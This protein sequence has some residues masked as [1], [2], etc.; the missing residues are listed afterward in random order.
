[1]TLRAAP[2]LSQVF[3]ATGKHDDAS[4]AVR[5][6]WVYIA[7]GIA[8]LGQ[9]ALIGWLTQGQMQKA[10][11]REARMDQ[12][13]EALALC[14]EGNVQAIRKRC[15]TLALE[16]DAAPTPMTEQ[17]VVENDTSGLV[18]SR[19]LM[20]DAPSTVGFNPRQ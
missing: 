8:I 11:L 13:R 2:S 3:N 4:R 20:V 15:V 6:S 12:Q 17:L 19:V 7:A 16:G 5:I 1:M 18:G 10:Q 14:R 9:L